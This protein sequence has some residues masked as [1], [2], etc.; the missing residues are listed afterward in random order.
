VRGNYLQ[1]LGIRLLSGRFFTP[2]DTADS[3]LVAIV[4]HKLAE[5][6]WPGS[7]PI[8]RRLRLGTKEMQTPWAT[9]VEKSPTSKTPRRKPQPRSSTISRVEQF[10]K[11]IGSFASPT[12][13]NGNSGYIAVRTAI[14]PEQIA[15]AL[16]ASVRSMD[17]Q[18]PL[19]QIQSMEQAVSDS[20][21]PRRFNTV[22]ISSFAIAAVLLAALGIYSV[23]AFSAALRAQEMAIR[24]ALGSQRSG[25]LSLVFVSAAKLAIAGCALGLLGAAAASRLMQS[26]L[27]GV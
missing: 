8:G 27:F 26:L 9:V 4:N 17:P 5:H 10:E 3:Q 6:Y 25:I 13:V 24:I 16:R 12:D 11:S 2:A 15:N 20:E 14:A 18:L 23:I 1:A 22:L 19:A 7:D 21:A